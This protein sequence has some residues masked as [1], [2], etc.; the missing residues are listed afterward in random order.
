MHPAGPVATSGGG[1]GGGA[2]LARLSPDTAIVVV[3]AWLVGALLVTAL[4]T[5][6][7]EIS[8]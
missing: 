4:F 5:E 7:A 6:R 3:A 8:G 2:A 1:P